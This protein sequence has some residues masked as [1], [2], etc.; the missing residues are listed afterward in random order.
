MK[1]NTAT[2]AILTLLVSLAAAQSARAT[3]VDVYA[4]A[5]SV[6]GG[7]VPVSTIQLKAGQ[8]FY[9]S[10]DPNDLWKAGNVLPRWSN[11]DGL[12]RNLFA[13][14]SDESGEKAGTW[15]GKDWGP[16][17]LNGF[18]A[19]FGALV[20]KVGG[21]YILL[22]HEFAGPAPAAGVLQL[23][24]WD[25]NNSDNGGYITVNVHTPEVST[26]LAGALLLIPF[27]A[28]ALRSFRKNRSV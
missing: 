27:G 21:K 3:L 26:I 23:M 25:S 14:G 17:T 16:Y 13:T 9:V 2:K 15:I 18:T 1:T 4:K 12:V 8:Q 5:N 20:G 10:V 11:A 6:A 19:P 28:S 7:G 24:Y 22:G